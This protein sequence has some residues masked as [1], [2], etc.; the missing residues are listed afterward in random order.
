MSNSGNSLAEKSGTFPD[1]QNPRA[2]YS[3]RSLMPL[4]SQIHVGRHVTPKL[5]ASAEAL[6]KEDRELGLRS[7]LKYNKTK[8]P[9]TEGLFRD[10]D[11]NLTSLPAHPYS[12]T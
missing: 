6:A 11:T 7:N 12:P 3:C 1:R 4:S 10:H 9:L 5:Y 2:F 8:S